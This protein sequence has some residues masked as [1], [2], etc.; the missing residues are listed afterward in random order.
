MS[1]LL[2]VNI[3]SHNPAHSSSGIIFP[4]N[5]QTMTGHRVN[6]SLGAFSHQLICIQHLSIKLKKLLLL[7]VI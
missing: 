6:R 7:T 3:V 2:T 1:V 5:L 4:L